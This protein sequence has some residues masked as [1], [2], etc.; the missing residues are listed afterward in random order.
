MKLYNFLSI[1]LLATMAIVFNGCKDDSDTEKPVIANLKLGINNNHVAYI[2]TDMHIEAEIIAAGKIASVTVEI[3]SENGSGDEIE[4]EYADYA[5]QKNATFHKHI[6]IPAG[7]HAGEYH[8]HLTVTDMEGNSTTVEED[9]SIEASTDTEKPNLSISAA[10]AENAAF[11]AGQSISISGR[12]TDNVAVGGMMAVL[13]R[14]GVEVSAERLIIMYI[15]HFQ[16]KTE[17]DFNAS[18]NAG[19]EYDKNLTPALIQ[20]ENAWQSGKYYILVRT[21]DPVGNITESQLYP[22]NINL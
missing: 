19:A 18:I 13:I 8:F 20:G 12:V 1:S 7:T 4:A 2:G 9:I 16:D 15:S 17:V 14:D 10:P 11:S 22:I 6:D 5:G 3:H 21:W